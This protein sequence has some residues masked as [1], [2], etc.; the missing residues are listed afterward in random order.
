MRGP[1]RIS[2]HLVGK[3]SWNIWIS[4]WDSQRS[5]SGLWISDSEDGAT[6]I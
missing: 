1:W 3:E 2:E 5:M 6:R 4:T